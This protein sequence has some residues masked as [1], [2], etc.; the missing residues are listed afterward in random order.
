MTILLSNLSNNNKKIISIK[1]I[2]DIFEQQ[3]NAFE[4]IED[5]HEV[6]LQLK[7]DQLK[8]EIN[9]LKQQKEK[10]LGD[11]RKSIN[12]EKTAWLE[13]KELEKK[14]AE[15]VGYKIGYDAGYEDVF[16]QYESLIN[17]ANQIATSAKQDYDKTINKHE[18]AIL[19]LAITIAEKIIANKLEEKPE[20]FI[21]M[22]KQAIQDLK[23]SSQV[24]IYVH[25]DNYQLILNQKEE[26]EQMVRKEDVIS[27]YNDRELDVGD[28][29]IKHPYGQIDVSIDTQL[30]QIKH[31]L[32]EKISER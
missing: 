12:K 26:L 9:H 14:Q 29:L 7:I 21:D 15:E 4:N 23:D 28:C 13:Q 16:K 19:E 32:E 10:V 20:S 17:E 2:T 1:K 30:Q 5:D 11:L 6:T 3:E 25:P 27:V 18:Y 22:V 24:E 8:H 31:V